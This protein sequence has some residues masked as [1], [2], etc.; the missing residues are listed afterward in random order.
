MKPNMSF[1]DTI[2]RLFVGIVIGGAFG[3]FSNPI[4]VLAVYPIVTALIAWDPIY[5]K[6]GWFTVEVN[7]YIKETVENK[8][9]PVSKPAKLS[10]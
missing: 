4:G 7:P 9:A 6:M 10:A 2:I 3:A 5:Q 8:K 1:F